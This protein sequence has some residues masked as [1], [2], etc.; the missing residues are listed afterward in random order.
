MS[1]LDSPPR[2][3]EEFIVVKSKKMAKEASIER[4]A[5]ARETRLARQQITNLE[6]LFETELTAHNIL[7]LV[8]KADTYGSLEAIVGSLKNIKSDLI[9]LNIIH[10]SVGGINVNDINLAITTNS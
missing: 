8:I 1:G 2:A 4:A 3:G 6:S 7:N 10:D 5:K 9:K